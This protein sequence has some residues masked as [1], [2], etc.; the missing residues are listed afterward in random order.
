MT[1]D[2][3]I[4]MERSHVLFLGGRSGVGKTS[5]AMELHHLLSAADVQH[6]VIEGDTLDLAYPAP[7][8]HHLAER[9]LADL[10]RNYRALGYRRLIYTN[11][12]S[13][14]ETETLAAAMGDD[15][16]VTA[17]LLTS[18]E[19]AARERLTGR[20]RGSDLQASLERSARRAAELDATAPEWV[21]RLNTDGQS[22]D[23]LARQLWAWAGWP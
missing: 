7:W 12:V 6:S 5:V 13:V 20:E 22:L 10:W 14:L 19:A 15:P 4:D 9:N 1:S 11:T 3:L 21:R 16:L 17:V 18:S 2:V 8:A 23:T